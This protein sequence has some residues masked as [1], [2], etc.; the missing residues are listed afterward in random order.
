MTRS[1]PTLLLGIALLSGC[2]SRSERLAL[3]R[4]TF[5]PKGTARL[6]SNDDSLRLSIAL[7]IRN[8]GPS[9]AVLDSFSA[10][11][12]ARAPLGVLSHGGTSRILPGAVD[13][14]QIHLAVA[15]SNLMAIATGLLFSPPD[16]LSATGVAWI[17]GWF[18]MGAHPFQVGVPYSAV[19]DGVKG[20]FAKGLDR[21]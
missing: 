1:L 12:R 8:P 18:G 6:E 14:V 19:Q 3:R 10:L 17:P 4:C 9:A 20:I 16:S 15:Q 11:V 2:A 7:E 21:N 5:A 13:T